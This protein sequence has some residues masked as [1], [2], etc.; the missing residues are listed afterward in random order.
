MR[1]VDPIPLDLSSVNETIISSKKLKED[2]I[3]IKDISPDNSNSPWAVSQP[4][5]KKTMIITKKMF[6]YNYNNIVRISI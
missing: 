6:N 1:T 3:T 5:V 2:D 4:Q